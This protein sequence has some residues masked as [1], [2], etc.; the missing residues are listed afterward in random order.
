[1]SSVRAGSGE[2]AYEVV[3]RVL[4][5]SGL[6]EQMYVEQQLQNVLGIPDIGVEQ[7]GRR[8]CVDASTRVQPEGAERGA[9]PV[10]HGQ[11]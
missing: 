6:L 11:I 9:V 4:A 1:P 7:R 5:Q 10:V 2:A 8:V 3:E